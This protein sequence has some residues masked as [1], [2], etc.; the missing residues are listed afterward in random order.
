M[1]MK[2]FWK[3][4]H[5]LSILSYSSEMRMADLDDHLPAT[6]SRYGSMRGNLVS[7]PFHRLVFSRSRRAVMASMTADLICL[8][9]NVMIDMERKEKLTPVRPFSSHLQP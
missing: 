6:V 5:R 3:N 8:V 2:L 4:A 9:S 7:Y 1:E